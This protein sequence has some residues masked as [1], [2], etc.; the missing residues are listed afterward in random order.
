MPDLWTKLHPHHI[1]PPSVPTEYPKWVKR[2][3]GQSVVVKSRLEEAQVTGQ[4]LEEDESEPHCETVN[5]LFASRP[6]VEEPL[7]EKTQL[8]LEAQSLGIEVDRR[9]GVKKLRKE[10]EARR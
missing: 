9:W 7:P 2:A 8:Q 6:V 1:V 5:H 10:I 3:D 4:E